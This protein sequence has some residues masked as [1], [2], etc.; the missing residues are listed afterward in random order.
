ME[1]CRCE[2]P[3]QWTPHTYPGTAH[4]RTPRG[5]QCDQRRPP[6]GRNWPALPTPGKI[7]HWL[8]F[9]IL[10]TETPHYVER[11]S[12]FSWQKSWVCW[13]RIHI[14]WKESSY[15][16]EKKFIFCGEKVHIL[17]RE[18]RESPDCGEKDSRL[19]GKKIPDFV[20]RKV[21]CCELNKKYI[22]LVERKTRFSE[23]VSKK[24][25]LW[26][27]R[28]SRIHAGFGTKNLPP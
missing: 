3:L 13:N 28:R 21:R 22:L 27:R 23:K 5:S 26:R 10:R 4:S 20:E 7:K 17:W 15:F 2:T 6:W 25:V 11:M 14:L 18:W 8:I 19:C 9:Q 12:I 1:M 24:K 16:V